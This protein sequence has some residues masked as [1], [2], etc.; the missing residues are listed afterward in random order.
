[1]ALTPWGKRHETLQR[2]EHFLADCCGA[3]H[4]P[5]KKFTKGA[6]AWLTRRR[7]SDDLEM[8][9]LVF[10]AAL[11]AKG[12]EVD[13]IHFPPRLCDDH[14]A[15]NQA[16]LYDISLEEIVSYKIAHFF[17]R[18]QGHEVTGVHKAVLEH[19]ER[20]L[21]SLAL[22]WAGGRKEKAAEALGLHRN[23]LRK[24]IRDLDIPMPRRDEGALR[25]RR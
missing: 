19:V 4:L 15:F 1:M 17:E 11:L 3:F 9:R 7:W 25:H 8:K 16:H 10:T 14:E 22:V 20:P 2:A 5:E 6:K 23:T 24:K 18:L 21:I 13:A 12:A